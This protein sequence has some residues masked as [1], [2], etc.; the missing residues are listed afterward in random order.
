MGEYTEQKKE[1]ING[2]GDKLGKG[3]IKTL[4][5]YVNIYTDFILLYVCIYGKWILLFSEISNP[6]IKVGSY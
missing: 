3:F 2:K 6:F 4:L 1:R 5:F